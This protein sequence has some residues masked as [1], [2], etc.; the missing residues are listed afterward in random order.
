M[1]PFA[2]MVAL[3]FPGVVLQTLAQSAL[4]SDF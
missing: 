2:A 3:M 1:L 4:R